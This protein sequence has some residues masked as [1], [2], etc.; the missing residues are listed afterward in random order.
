MLVC[1]KRFKFAHAY[2]D[3]SEDR[4]EV[5]HHLVTNISM[6][7]SLITLAASSPVRKSPQIVTAD[8]SCMFC[9]VRINDLHT[10]VI[11]IQ[12]VQ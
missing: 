12:N 11:H 9:A 2:L 6:N 10:Y 8:L 4:V 5:C 3:P 1:Q 7:H